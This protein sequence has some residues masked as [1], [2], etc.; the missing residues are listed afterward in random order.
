MTFREKSNDKLDTLYEENGELIKAFL[1]LP[2]KKEKPIPR[3]AIYPGSF[4]P[5]HLGHDDILK[6]ALKIFD[7]VIVAIGLNPEKTSGTIPELVED[8]Q[9]RIST[10]LREKSSVVYFHGLL[11]KEVVRV[12]A[13]AVIRGLRN[14]HDLQYEMNNQYW[15]EDLGLE[16][17]IV[18]FVC[19]RKLS[20]ISSSAI[21]S[22]G[23]ING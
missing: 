14:G 18:Y 8:V 23:K 2:L 21:R 19:D 17:P 5:W 6:K 1:S 4:N 9:S 15:N 11:A 3:V 12:G 7:K 13:V 22:L 16:V 10:E 20:H